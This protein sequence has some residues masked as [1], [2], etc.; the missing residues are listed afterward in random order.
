[1]A[2]VRVDKWLW[3]VRIYKSR[4]MATDACKEGKIKVAG[5][6][7]KP[8]FLVGEKEE[9]LVKKDGFNFQYR[10]LGLIEKRVGAAIAITCYE[11]ITPEAEK[12]KY[13]T[14]FTNATGRAE[15]RER[16]SGRPTKR[17]RRDIDGFKDSDDDD[18]FDTP[19]DEVLTSDQLTDLDD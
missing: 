7:V 10:V 2:K 19:D 1:M 14:W 18:D 15:I 8:S 11:D 4:T 5:L 3:S 17:E 6:N 13:E 9:I 16:G 12:F